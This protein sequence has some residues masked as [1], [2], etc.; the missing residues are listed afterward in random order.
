MEE[1]AK[2]IDGV[3]IEKAAEDIEN[4]FLYLENQRKKNALE[5]YEETLTEQTSMRHRWKNHRNT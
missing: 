1:I 2:I 3:G 5:Q 4:F